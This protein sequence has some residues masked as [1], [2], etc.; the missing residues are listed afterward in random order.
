MSLPDNL[1]GALVLS[2]IDFFL[3]FLFISAIGVLISILS[4]LVNVN[5]N[6]TAVRKR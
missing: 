2:F 3:S 5:F 6:G 1:T 4:K